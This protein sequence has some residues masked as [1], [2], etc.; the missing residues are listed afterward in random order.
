MSQVSLR[1]QPGRKTGSRE[2]RRIRRTGQVPAVVYGPELA[3]L[4]VQVDAHDLH[5]ALHTEAGTNAIITLEIDGGDTLT[6]MARVIDRHP[7]RNEY[8][9]IDFVTV[10]LSKKV[11]AEVALHFEG[12]PAGVREGGVFSPRRTSVHVEVLPTEIPAFIA[13]DVS[14][15]EVGGSLRVEDLPVIEGVEYQEDP[16][17]VVMSVTTPAAEIEEP[18]AELQLGEGEELEEGEQP[19]DGAEQADAGE[20]GESGGDE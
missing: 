17:A 12:T 4:P 7:Y 19:E 6:T 20:E 5:V 9:H 2:S 18:E 15:V 1:A 3:P 13:L 16:D 11:T 8:R 14:E 10:D